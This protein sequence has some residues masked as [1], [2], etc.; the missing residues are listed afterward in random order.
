MPGPL[1]GLARGGELHPV[2]LHFDRCNTIYLNCSQL[3]SCD[4][5]MMQAAAAFWMR[6]AL[7]EANNPMQAWP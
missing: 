1:K 7:G 4:G 6:S 2:R 3:A 5:R